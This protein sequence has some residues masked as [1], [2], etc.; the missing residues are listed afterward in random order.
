[1]HKLVLNFFG[2]LRSLLQ[3]SRV[4]IVFTIMTLLLYWIQDLAGFNYSFL[5]FIKPLL[6]SLLSISSSISDGSIQIFAA[7][8][9]FKYAIANIILLFLYMFTHFLN[10]V[11]DKTEELYCDGRN[12]IK[13]MEE[14]ALNTKLELNAKLEQKK[15]KRFDVYV[16]LMEKK[17]FSQQVANVDMKEQANILNKFLIEKLAVNPKAYG[18]GYIYSFGNIEKIDGVLDVFFKAIHSKAPVN[19]IVCV[20]VMGANEVFEKQQL[21]RLASLNIT[22]KIIAMPDTVWRYRF[23][24]KT[25]YETSQLGDFKSQGEEFEVHEFKD[26]FGV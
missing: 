11:V 19:Y 20:Q 3:L 1:M 5:N 22:N 10:G 2:M 25:K 17:K 15:L 24:E 21:E 26:N 23:N 9:E 4:L 12:A 6:E 18:E 8:F 16:G 13:K 7:E 14:N